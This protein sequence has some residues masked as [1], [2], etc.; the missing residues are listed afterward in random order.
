MTTDGSPA[1][2]GERL[3]WNP[4]RPRPRPGGPVGPGPV[5]AL[6]PVPG[7]SGPVGGSR[8]PMQMPDQLTQWGP[9][10]GFAWDLASDGRTRR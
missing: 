2:F 6:A 9:R 1:S 3:T 8:D 5:S 10:L 4:E 7:A